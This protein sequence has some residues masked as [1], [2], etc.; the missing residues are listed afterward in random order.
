M[1]MKSKHGKCLD[2]GQRN[3]NG[4]KVQ[5]WDCK[6]SRQAQ[7]WSYGGSKLSAASKAKG[8][9]SDSVSGS[10]TSSG[11][12]PSASGA[13]GSSSD[14]VS[15]VTSSGVSSSASSAADLQEKK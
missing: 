6:T 11:V 9:S 2:A 12:S 4:G 3:K 5:M 10:V 15:A 8:S 14:S 7:M 1:G 13:A